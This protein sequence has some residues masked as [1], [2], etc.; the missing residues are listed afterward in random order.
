L[1]KKK[2]D[3]P[4]DA[5]YLLRTLHQ[6]GYEAYLVGGCVRDLLREAE[7]HDWD[8][9]T[10]ALPTQ[11]KQ[12][13]TGHR[14]FET[15]IKHGT[16]TIL[17][18]EKPFEVTTYRIDGTYSDGR[19]PDSVQFSKRLW[20][21]LSRRDFT[22]NAIAMD[23]TGVIQDPFQ[24]LEDIRHGII[25]CAGEPD[26]RF[27]EDGLRVLRA[28]RFS[29]VL[30][31]SIHA[32]TANAIHQHKTILERVS[33]ERINTEVKKLLV[34]PRAGDVLR[35]YPDVFC[36]FWP[37]LAPLVALEQNNPWHCF[38]GWE[39]T[40]HALEAAP[41]DVVLKLAVLLHDIGKPACKT[42]DANGID[43]FYG[44]AS[45]S[46]KMANQMLRALKFDRDTR[47]KVVCLVENH[48]AAICATDKN[49][50]RWLHKLGREMFFQLLEVKRADN[51]GQAY[52]TVRER[53]DELQRIQCRAGEMLAEEQCFSIKD[54]AVNGKDILNTGIPEGPEIGR[55]LNN[56][57]D[58]IL[59][60]EVQ[61]EKERLLNLI[62][63]L[64][65]R[66][67]DADCKE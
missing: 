35:E 48:D 23:E 63:S 19:H 17:L 28:L 42:T 8:I 50:R 27:Q 21:D 40:I 29:A 15:G 24:G 39:H 18:N 20:D 62:P 43:H 38:G 46:A 49:I 6:A 36:Q 55:I 31:Y 59:N 57:M 7:P 41:A 34:G 54:L 25:R 5:V 37:D 67:H 33:A 53:L 52:E 22:M 32:D 51:M 11:T 61:N 65:A 45:V 26:Q 16:V 12:C 3:I 13:F 10:S 2:F 64:A 60:G 66:S 58:K 47:Q 30:E 1:P 4:P 14:I 56:L 9:C 44:H